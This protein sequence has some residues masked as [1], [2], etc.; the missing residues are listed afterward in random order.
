MSFDGLCTLKIGPKC[1]NR[2]STDLGD[3]G[4]DKLQRNVS[5]VLMELCRAH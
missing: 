5:A 3:N 4:G 1:G 2:T